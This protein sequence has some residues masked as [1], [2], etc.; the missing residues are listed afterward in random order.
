ML[1]PLLLIISWRFGRTR[2]FWI[3]ASIAAVS[4]VLSEWGWRNYSI[5]NFYLLPTRAWELLIGSLIAFRHSFGP[6][7]PSL[8]RPLR[9]VLAGTGFAAIVVSILVFD[10]ETPFPSLYAVLPTLGAALIIVYGN[11]KDLTSRLL[12]LRLIVFIGMLSYSAYLWH[13]PVFAFLRI[14]VFQELTSLHL[15]L[16][17][18]VSLLLAAFTWY[19]V[20]QPFR[21]RVLPSTT[22]ILRFSGAGL[23]VLLLAGSAINVAGKQEQLDGLSGERDYLKQ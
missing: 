21:R 4:F 9:E 22:G 19:F 14:R 10:R 1:F 3:T 20:E 18:L 6:A 13:Q 5:A 16:A 17:A 15:L 8:S 12:S 7:T 11:G 23:C 2:L